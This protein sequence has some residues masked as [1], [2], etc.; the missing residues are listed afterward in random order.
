MGDFWVESITW[1]WP[2]AF[3]AA[4]SWLG[5]WCWSR[6]VMLWCRV[7][8]APECQNNA[9]IFVRHSLNHESSLSIFILLSSFRVVSHSGPQTYMLL[10]VFPVQGGFLQLGSSDVQHAHTA[11]RG[12]TRI[13]GMRATTPPW[14]LRLWVFQHRTRTAHALWM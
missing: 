8:C 13:R 9:S 7:C 11:V 4:R 3:S 6:E 12:S 14:I 5:S 2:T 10:Y 1:S